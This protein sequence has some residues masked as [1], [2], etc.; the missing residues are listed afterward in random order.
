M[1]TV[2]E[3]RRREF[4]NRKRRI[5]GDKGMDLSPEWFAITKKLCMEGYNGVTG[6]SV[7]SYRSHHSAGAIFI[8]YFL[9]SC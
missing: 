3:K 9:F 6:E 5:N 8:Y 7:V 2:E 1:I 4:T